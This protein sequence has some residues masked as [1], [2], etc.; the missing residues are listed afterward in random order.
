MQNRANEARRLRISQS[1]GQGCRCILQP[2]GQEGPLAGQ[3][4][5]SISLNFTGPSGANQRTGDGEIEESVPLSLRCSQMN[6][7]EIVKNLRTFTKQRG[8]IRKWWYENI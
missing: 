6:C 3:D 2:Q 4:P 8:D 1:G 7:V 5:L